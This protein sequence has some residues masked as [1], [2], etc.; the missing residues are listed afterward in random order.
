MTTS[1]P[2]EKSILAEQDAKIKRRLRVVR[3]VAIADFIL[4]GVLVAAS[5]LFFNNREL[6]SVLGP[7]HGIN[8]LLLVMVV[9]LGAVDKLWRWW[10]PVITFLTGGPLGAFM[11]EMIISRQLKKVELR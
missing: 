2:A 7:I 10:F 9:S 6:V 5:R 11:G 1:Q 4:L 3:F 8:Y